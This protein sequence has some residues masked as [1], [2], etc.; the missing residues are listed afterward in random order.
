[1][2]QASTKKPAEGPAAADNSA[3]KRLGLNALDRIGN[4]PLLRLG[5]IARDVAEVLPLP[6][7]ERYLPETMN[8][9]QVDH[10]LEGVP[11]N[12]PRGLRDRPHSIFHHG[13]S[14]PARNGCGMKSQSQ[15]SGTDPTFHTGHPT[16]FAN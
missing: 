10:L 5:R 12:A 14:P 1:M 9:L 7:T 2:A 13:G 8:E 4:T 3:P 16:R 11:V 15:T 6:R